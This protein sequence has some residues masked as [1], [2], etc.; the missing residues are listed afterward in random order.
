MAV[1]E[2]LSQIFRDAME[3]LPSVSEKTMMGGVC[4]FVNDHMVG[5]AHRDKT[6]RRLFMFRVGLDNVARAEAI[7][8]G[9]KLVQGGRHMRGFYFVEAEDCAPD[10]FA[11]WLS[12]AVSHA[13]SLP[14]K[15][16]KS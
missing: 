12:L 4:F 14:P 7:G 2:P 16:P 8:G 5:G 3:G 11:N 9:E 1:D 13:L 6:G 15:E 10:R